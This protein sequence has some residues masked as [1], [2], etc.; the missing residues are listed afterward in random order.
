MPLWT[1]DQSPNWDSNLK[2]KNVYQAT[3]AGWVNK[4]TGELVVAVRNLLQR[5]TVVNKFESFSVV[6]PKPTFRAGDVLTVVARYQKPVVVTSNTHH[7][8]TLRFQ[9]DRAS[10]ISLTYLEGSGS[11]ELTFQTQVPPFCS[12]EF[13]LATEIFLKNN[14]GG[15]EDAATKQ[16][17]P[18]HYDLEAITVISVDSAIPQVTAQE[19]EIKSIKKTQQ[20]RISL[21]FD[22]VMKVQGAPSIELTFGEETAQA[23]YSKSLSSAQKLV[24]AYTLSDKDRLS[25]DLNIAN[26]ITLNGGAIADAVENQADLK[27]ATFDPAEIKLG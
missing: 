24:F 4:E 9:Q 25:G 6:N 14:Q 10:H 3:E 19:A 21:T 20:L 15:I 7:K 23:I 17:L 5:Q 11:Q 1:R 22:K 26:Q 18:L 12:G 2:G 13:R 8:P 16:P 27:F